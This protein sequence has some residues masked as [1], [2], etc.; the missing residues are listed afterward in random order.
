MGEYVRDHLE[1]KCILDDE[2]KKGKKIVFGNGCFDL[3]H[4]GHIR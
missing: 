4:V 2:R 1:L 3:L